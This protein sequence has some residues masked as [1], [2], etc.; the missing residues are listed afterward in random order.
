[1][2]T[3]GTICALLELTLGTICA[4]CCVLLFYFSDV[5]SSQMWIEFDAS[6]PAHLRCSADQVKRTF[7]AAKADGTIRTYLGGFNRWKRRASEN[8]LCHLPA[9]PFYVAVLS[10]VPLLS[11]YDRL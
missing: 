1:M 10:A 3:L 5:F 4:L 11:V 6:M 9:N 8:S 7:L 2:R